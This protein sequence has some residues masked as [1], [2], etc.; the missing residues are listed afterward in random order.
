MF[1]APTFPAPLV[2]PTGTDAVQALELRE[3]YKEK[4]RLYR[5]CKNMEKSL[6][7]HIHTAI[8]DKYIEHL[9][10]DDTGLLEEDIPTVLE[11]LF[12]NYGKIPSE[13]VKDRE[14]EVLTMTFNPT[15][16]MVIL[17]RPIEQLQ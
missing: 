13:E 11:Y 1:I 4:A 3:S 17:Y 6:L 10:D 8:D 15:E 2:I 9:V 12:T 14:A 7:R 16:P 5:E